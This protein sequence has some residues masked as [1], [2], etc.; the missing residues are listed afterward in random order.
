MRTLIAVVLFLILS[1]QGCNTGYEIYKKTEGVTFGYK[2][3][4]ARNEAGE[5][6]PAILLMVRNENEH[7]IDYKL[8]VD[9]YYEGLLRETGELD[10]CV[11][12]KRTRK[13]KLNGVYLISDKFT[14]DQIKSSDFKVELN[15]IEVAKIESCNRED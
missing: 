8:S 11:P 7:A 9:F 12:A 1:A 10:Y 3:A 13:G 6:V 4:E 15:G 14:S 5:R 2:W